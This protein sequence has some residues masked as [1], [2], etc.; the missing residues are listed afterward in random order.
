MP[1][2]KN[3]PFPA[4][5]KTKLTVPETAK[6]KWTENLFKSYGKE[7]N[8]EWIYRELKAAKDWS[9][10]N[11]VPIFVGEF[12]SF[13]KFAALDDRCRHAEAVYSALGKLDIP[14]AWWEWDQGFTMF[15]PETS[16]IAGCMQK[17][18][19]LFDSN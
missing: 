15:K 18:I 10:K 8:A 19:G 5:E 9:E 7:A 11:K 2:A 6:G 14:N 3:I 16:E 4:D 12:G 1:E 13:N 17:A